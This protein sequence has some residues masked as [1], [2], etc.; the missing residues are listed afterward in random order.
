[1]RQLRT[2]ISLNP[3][4]PPKKIEVGEI[5]LAQINNSWQRIRIESRNSTYCLIFA[6][7][8]GGEMMWFST[9]KIFDCKTDYKTLPAQVHR[10]SLYG[11]KH[12]INDKLI[13]QNEL[14]SQHLLGKLIVAEIQTKES[15]FNGA[16]DIIANEIASEVNIN[17]LMLKKLY[18]YE[19]RPIFNWD[20]TKSMEITSVDDAG[21]IF[22]Y[23]RDEKTLE[24]KHLMVWLIFD[25]AKNEEELVKIM[26]NKMK[27]QTVE[28][29]PT[30]TIQVN[31]SDM[32]KLT[33]K[34][35]AILKAKLRR[36]NVVNVRC[37][38]FDSSYRLLVQIFLQNKQFHSLYFLNDLIKR[39]QLLFQ[40]T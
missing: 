12:L 6:I 30:N 1:M 16:I 34:A 40:K 18:D 27:Y 7:D 9:T 20:R 17:A 23:F 35:V 39:M 25:L 8:V 5:Y 19:S 15:E 11:L 10:F 2:T 13:I 4:F 3:K 28:L 31:L 14:I 29:V 37:L 32:P 36:N 26:A 21:N 33:D 38:G 24:D 22:G